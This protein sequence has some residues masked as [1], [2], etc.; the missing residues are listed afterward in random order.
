MPTFTGASNVVY[1]GNP[2]SS[3]PKKGYFKKYFWNFS[4]TGDYVYYNNK[5]YLRI[6]KMHV[7]LGWTCINGPGWTEPLPS[8]GYYLI[9]PYTGAPGTITVRVRSRHT[10]YGSTTETKTF[11]FNGSNKLEIKTW[12]PWPTNYTLKTGNLTWT[13]S[14][15][16]ELPN[17]G[18]LFNVYVTTPYSKTYEY[19]DWGNIGSDQRYPA[20]D[21]NNP[22]VQYWNG[23]KWVTNKI[24]RWNG[25]SWQNIPGKRYSGSSWD[26]VRG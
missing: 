7:N 10:N 26:E 15:D 4:I 3:E 16:I 21:P 23:S 6:T 18:G 9:Y 17:D 24:K 20:W 1:P 25:S 11:T 22:G 8:G 19:S 14:V 2:T 12:N 13:G 5:R